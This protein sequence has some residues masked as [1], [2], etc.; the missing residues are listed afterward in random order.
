MKEPNIGE[1]LKENLESRVDFKLEPGT[2]GEIILDGNKVGDVLFNNYGDYYA[3]DAILLFE[4]FRKKRIGMVVYKRLANSLDKPLRSGK[5]LSEDSEHVW[6][7]LVTEGLAKRIG[8]IPSGRG[9][10]EWVK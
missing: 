10:Y 4:K 6:Q 7:K 8:D 9:L 5:Q 3:L 1:N 2:F